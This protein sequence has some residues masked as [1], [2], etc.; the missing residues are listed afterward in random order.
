MLLTSTFGIDKAISSFVF[1]IA[2][3]EDP[4]ASV[5]QDTIL[6]YLQQESI[7][8]KYSCNVSEKTK[9]DLR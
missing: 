8:N 3:D 6:R 4:R 9:D 1:E 5:E 7:C 2:F